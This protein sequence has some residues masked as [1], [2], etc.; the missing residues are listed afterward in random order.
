[1]YDSTE[2]SNPGHVLEIEKEDSREDVYL[3]LVWAI[4]KQLE[5]NV[6]KYARKQS[7]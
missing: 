2:N 5:S 1:M 3:D 6:W 7:E 4:Q